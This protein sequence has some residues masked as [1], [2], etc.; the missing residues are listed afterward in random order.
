MA[1]WTLTT[2][3]RMSRTMLCGWSELKIKWAVCTLRSWARKTSLSSWSR[4]R[5]NQ[6]AR[7]RT[8][9]TLCLWTSATNQ[10]KSIKKNYSATS[11]AASVEWLCKANRLLVSSRRPNLFFSLGRWIGESAIFN[12]Y[13]WSWKY[14]IESRKAIKWKRWVKSIRKHFRC[15]QCLRIKGRNNQ[16]AWIDI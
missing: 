12:P 4:C 8:L 14:S 11:Q 7:K 1:L 5:G 2:C 15:I 9:L 3:S 16:C 13:S 10:F 6:L